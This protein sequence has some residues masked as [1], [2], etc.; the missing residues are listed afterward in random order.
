MIFYILKFM[1]YLIYYIR[2]L[3]KCVIIYKYMLRWRAIV[4]SHKMPF[5]GIRSF[6]K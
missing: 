6:A 2:Y 3:I 4:I 1:R 5:P